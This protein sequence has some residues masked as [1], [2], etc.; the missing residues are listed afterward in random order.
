[1]S[2][3]VVSLEKFSGPLELLLKLIEDKNLEITEIS[4]SSV[5]EDYLAWVSQAKENY[6][7]NVADFLQVAATLLLIKSRSILPTLEVTPEEKEEIMDLQAR[8]Q[9]YKIFKELG[10]RTKESWSYQPQ[11]FSRPSWVGKTIIFTPPTNVFPQDLLTS[12]LGLWE[13]FKSQIQIKLPEASIKRSIISLEDK[14][15]NIWQRLLAAKSKLNFK[16]LND[17]QEFKEE[18]VITFLALLELLKDDKITV[19]Q[20]NLFGEIEVEAN[21]HLN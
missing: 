9:L 16:D 8:L 2:G 17:K 5:T 21:K 13:R 19:N 12:F 20:D 6:L 10:M 1:M 4:L 14:I 11:M 15:T 7:E 3:F 18:I